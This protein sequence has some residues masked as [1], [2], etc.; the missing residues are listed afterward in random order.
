MSTRNPYIMDD[1]R[2]KPEATH[3]VLYILTMEDAQYYIERHLGREP[4]RKEL[5]EMESSI[6]KGVES[7]LECWDEVMNTACEI[8][9]D[10]LLK[11]N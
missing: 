1:L 5:D 4:T 6:R 11:A 10:N 7:G 3:A 2:D 8:A 9:V